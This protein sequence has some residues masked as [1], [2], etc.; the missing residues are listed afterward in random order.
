M[1]AP[2]RSTQPDT[3]Q[4][5]QIQPGLL[6]SNRLRNL[7]DLGLDL[8]FPP[9]CAGCNRVDTVWCATCQAEID[10]VD[11]PAPT[12]PGTESALDFIAATGP[13][14]GK[15]QQAIWS[16][17]F[18]NERKL[19]AIL[20]Q[21]LNNR[22]N[23]LNWTIDMVVGVPLHT[24]RLQERGYN[25]SQLMAQELASLQGLPIV[26]DAI[27]RRIDT[28]SQVGLDAVQR[29]ENMQNAFVARQD[30][31]HDKTILLIDDVYTT[32]ATLKACAAAALDAGAAAVYG[33]TLTMA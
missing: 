9:R 22:L 12:S 27:I 10:L 26:T 6:L 11:F 31:V 20:A 4:E 21:R 1:T 15:L 28:R 5:A 18:E 8:L 33:L 16:L 2:L 19:A 23:T 7:F 14:K 30:L 3:P 25:Q 13:H 17:K 24:N 32:G 29:Q